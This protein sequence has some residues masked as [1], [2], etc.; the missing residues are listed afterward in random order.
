[1]TV[2]ILLV[3]YLICALRTNVVFVV[4]FLTLIPALAMLT[5]AFWYQAADLTGNESKVETLFTAAGAF[6]FVTCMAGWYLLL[7]ILLDTV[8]FPL[9]LP[10]GDLSGIIK[11][12]RST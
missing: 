6:L 8:D 7:A 3:V 9:S 10:V 2:T 5:A 11:G 4:I 1:M 12:R